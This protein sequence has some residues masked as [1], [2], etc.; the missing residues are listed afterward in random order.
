[1][2]HNVYNS[3]QCEEAYALLPSCLEALDFASE[4]ENDTPQNRFRAIET[5][6]VLSN[7]FATETPI[8]NIELDVSRSFLANLYNLI[9]KLEP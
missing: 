7:G 4:P 3:T 9:V 8:E 2:Y 1:M 6:G 5:C